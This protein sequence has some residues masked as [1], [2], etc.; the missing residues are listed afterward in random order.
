MPNGLN[1]RRKRERVTFGQIVRSPLGKSAIAIA[2]RLGISLAGRAILGEL[3]R[4]KKI[5]RR[6][7]FVGNLAISLSSDVLVTRAVFGRVGLGLRSVATLAIGNVAEE[8]VKQQT[9]HLFNVFAVRRPAFARQTVRVQERAKGEN[10]RARVATGPPGK[11]DIYGK[12]ER[13]GIKRPRQ[14]RFLAVP[15]RARS[16]QR[17]VIARSLRPRLLLRRRDVFVLRQRHGRLPP[18]I[19]QRPQQRSGRLRMLYVLKPSV[20]IDARL[21]MR[22]RTERIVHRGYEIE[23]RKEFTRSFAEAQ[24]TA[25][26]AA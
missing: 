16:G 12:F 7:E 14:G 26:A 15:V 1:G 3:R 20:P 21:G 19:Y 5:S 13:G 6:T 17:Q 8:V 18:G 23:F 22:E 2:L 11:G 24:A 4:R 10:M 9:S 25:A